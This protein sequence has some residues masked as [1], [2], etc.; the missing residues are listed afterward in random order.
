[1]HRAIAIDVGEAAPGSVLLS[2]VVGIALATGGFAIGVGATGI[3]EGST[4]FWYLSRASG[5]VAY[6]LLWG[7][8]MWGLLLSTG[9]G[10]SWMRPPLLLDAHQFLS[11]AAVGFASFH[12]LVLMGDRFVSFSFLAIVVPFAGSYEPLLVACGQI[13]IWLSVLLIASFHLRRHL[14]GQVWRRLHY[15]SFV[16]FWLAWVHGL[17]LGSERAT[18]WASLLYLG[19]V[20]SVIFLTLYRVL[21]TPRLHGR[22]VGAATHQSG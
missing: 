17:A 1:M 7:S 19:T 14:G 3:T 21:S 12:G 13:A 9:T 10:R 11:A 15:A 8:V 6:L 18:L 4:S 20:A 5:F 2:T 16:A 22:V